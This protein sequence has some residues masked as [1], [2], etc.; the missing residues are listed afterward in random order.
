M[1]NIALITGGSRGIGKAI[2]V[3]LAKMGYHIW[4]NY[5]ANHEKA[6]ETKNIVEET[7]V[8]CTLLCFDIASRHDVS[9][10]LQ[11]Q[12]DSLD[13]E[14]DKI[15]ILVNNAGILKDNIFLWMTEQ[16]W[17]NVINTNLN[18]FFNVTKLIAPHMIHN[19]CG[20]IVNIS[21]Q[22]GLVGN[23]A[24]TNYSAAKAGLIAAT[25]TLAKEFGRS[26]VRVNA[27]VPGMIETDMIADT[28]NIKDFKKQIPLKRFGTAEEIA[29]T[30]AFL[31]SDKA[32]YITGAVFP[33]NG[34]LF[35]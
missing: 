14:K 5:R 11:K 16:E 1:A 29:H 20:S 19:E 3:E 6:Q 17:D 8:P 33:V 7:G 2:C 9:T 24:Q 13:P 4:L 23:Y 30:V 32:S 22:S 15:Q 34:G 35:S 26:K 31:C 28:H 12:I 10:M 27:V 18:G 21:S 25:R